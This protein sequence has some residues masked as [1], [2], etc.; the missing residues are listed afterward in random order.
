MKPVTAGII[1]YGRMA[2]MCHVKHMHESGL[3][4]LVGVCD[5]TEARRK[6]AE[7][8]GLK[9]TGELAELL[10]WDIEMVVVSTHSAQHHADV[11]KAAAAGKHIIVEKP[12]AVNASQAEEMAATA[13]D[14]GVSLTVFHN[15]HFDPDYCMV[16]SA[17][18]DGLLGNLVYV[19]NRTFGR[20]P[21]IN[22]GTPDYNPKWR[23]S[24]SAGGGTLLDWGPHWIEQVVDLAGARKVLHVCGD[25]RH[26]IWGDADD[27][28]R[29]E[30]IF[31]DGLRAVAARADI[32][33]YNPPDKW[34]I[35]G[36]DAT[37]HGPIGEDKQQAVGICGPDFEMKRTKAIEPQSLHEN[38]VAHLREGAPL[39]I[40][41]ELALRVMRIIQ[42]GIDSAKAGHGV[43]VDL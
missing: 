29:I 32:S 11:L 41:P 23:V 38:F 12:M 40:T 35:L 8:A 3:F 10:S 1:G 21:A 16:K 30:M 17:V 5:I 39:I 31:D 15:R 37:L 28:F 43:D 20:R 36:T 34:L 24:A 14:A 4:D 18:L 6:A 42:A 19:E 33:Y 2:E 26:V 22:F 9:A 25:V 7:A 27:F 13:Q